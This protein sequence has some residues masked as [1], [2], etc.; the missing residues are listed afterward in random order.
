MRSG[1]CAGG[2]FSLV[3][4]ARKRNLKRSG[5]RPDSALLRLAGCRV[6]REAVQ[7]RE[8][9]VIAAF[10]RSG[11]EVLVSP[12]KT[13]AFLSSGGFEPTGSTDAALVH[14]DSLWK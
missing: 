4:P 5:T 2:H 7:W 8:P 9:A 13:V 10:I 1:E 6:A 11:L 12:D 3:S 14:P